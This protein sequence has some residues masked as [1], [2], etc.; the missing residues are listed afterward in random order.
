MSGAVLSEAEV[1]ES[2]QKVSNWGRWGADDELGTLNYITPEKVVAAAA[3][4]RSGRVVSASHDL[5]PV[6]S[7]KNSGPLRHRMI[8]RGAHPHGA[9]DEMLLYNHGLHQTHVDALT[10]HFY[11]D[12]VYNG[13]DV[14]E[15][16]RAQGL[17][18]G[19]VYVQ[20]NGLVTRGVLLDVA[21]A[22]GVDW[23]DPSDTVTAA[24]LQAAEDLAGTRVE[25]GDAVLV[26]IGLGLREARTGPED[27]S[28][29]TGLGP[30]CPLWLHEREVALFGSDCPEKLPSAY[31]SI[32]L[33]WHI[34]A[35]VFMG[36]VLVDTVDMEAVA[37][38]AA[39]EGRSEFLYT[40]AP[41]RFA[42]GTGCP[43]NP[44]CVF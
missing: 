10:H 38:A 24:D 34:A 22:R 35:L 39:A 43:I 12:K 21:R 23:L 7:A 20:R 36:L 8:Y 28:L 2:F 13:R 29:R 1:L 32:G 16:V 6:H 37:E 18:F 44:L 4:V 3:L 26:R 11:E 15:V 5:S 42:G 9:A 14:A 41:L 33:T 25:S 17:A 40:Q 27:V 31:P 19:S 30:D